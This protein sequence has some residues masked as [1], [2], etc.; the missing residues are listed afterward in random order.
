MPVRFSARSVIAL[1]ASSLIF[2]A[3]HRSFGQFES[4][5]TLSSGQSLAQWAHD[6]QSDLI[7]EK[8]ETLDSIANHL[9]AEKA[10]VPG[11]DWQLMAFYSALDAPQQTEQDSREHIA[12]LENWMSQRPDSITARV[13]LATALIRWA[14]VAR[15]NGM[16]NTV[17]PEGAKLFL[18]R[19]RQA[20]VILD[21]SAK[22]QPMC[23]QWYLVMM[24]VG[25]AQSWD[26]ARM[27]QVMEDG[28]KFEPGY[29]YLYMQYANYVLPK[30]FG[31]PGDASSFARTSADAVGGDSGDMLYFQIAKRLITRG[32]GDFPVH[33]MDWPRLQRG[34]QALTSQYGQ[35]HRL[36][37]QLAFM[38]WKF[39]DATVARQQFALIGDN[40]NRGV[41]G[42]R[43]Y[44]DRARDWAQS[45]TMA[46][47]PG[48]ADGQS[49]PQN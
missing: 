12:H 6:L 19:V 25:T 39:Q 28:L 13:A 17:T 30:W 41:W 16:A 36:D 18:D 38:A 1:L 35:S 22:M 43:N 2:A 3:P 29:Y 15:G 11:G 14:W 21:G 4:N 47:L 33:E 48:Q 46:P 42:D 20:Q 40:W 31:H 32:D 26:L 5:E 24:E 8:F 23:P 7:A 34:Y 10:R 49:H 27:H 37:N 45:P 9:R 44:F